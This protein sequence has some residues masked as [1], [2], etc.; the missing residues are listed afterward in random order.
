MGRQDPAQ[1]PMRRVVVGAIVGLAF[2]LFVTVPWGTFA[3]PEAPGM[4][5]ALPASLG[6]M[7]LGAWVA[8]VTGLG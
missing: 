7:I 4:R 5:L 8:F 6:F 3:T 1:T 2:G